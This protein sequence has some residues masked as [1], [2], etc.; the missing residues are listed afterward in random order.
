MPDTLIFF[1]QLLLLNFINY[2]LLHLIYLYFLIQKSWLKFLLNED[3][4]LMIS[5]IG[6]NWNKFSIGTITFHPQKHNFS[7]SPLYFAILT[8]LS[9]LT[10]FHILQ[11]FQFRPNGLHD[12]S[13]EFLANI[14]K[15]EVNYY[16]LNFFAFFRFKLLQ[17]NK[18]TAL[19]VIQNIFYINDLS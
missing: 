9:L 2:S 3:Q 11:V 17:K 12:L 7:L 6:L 15:I 10:R 8:Y 18:L 13:H 19:K 14:E 4:P 5:G 1:S 16:I